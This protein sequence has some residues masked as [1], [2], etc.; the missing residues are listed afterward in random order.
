M[1]SVT[2]L[3]YRTRLA[4]LSGALAFLLA[5][6]SPSLAQGKPRAS[7]TTT[8]PAPSG[9][10]A[11][12]S[13]M[14]GLYPADKPGATVIVVKDGKTVFRQAYGMADLELGVPMKPE[15]V[16]RL[17][18]ITKQFTATAILML[19]EEGKLSLQDPIE[20]Y[21]PGY[22]THDKV[23]T[24]EHLLT[25]TS[26]IQSYTAI[27]GWM[28][29]RIIVPMKPL[30]LIDGFKNAPMTFDPGEKYLYNNSGF[31]LLGAI[32]EKVSGM[33]YAEFVEGRIFKPL[34]MTSSYYGDTERIIKNRVPGYTD[35]DQVVKNMAYLSMT[36]PYSAG[37]LL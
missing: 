25:H 20:K 3:S 24:I 9:A 29:S 19:A 33:P 27:P 14:K 16:L 7:S 11:F 22:P 6:A 4:R 15:M 18:S 34:G 26:G 1:I 10:A 8:T 30:E 2:S 32:I 12:E 36:Q 13:A 5:S 28:T 23:I 21:L 37:S 17:G 31:I 35:D